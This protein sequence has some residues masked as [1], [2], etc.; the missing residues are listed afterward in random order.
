MPEAFTE[1]FQKHLRS[2]SETV[3]KM[4][5]SN[6]SKE[7]QKHFRSFS[8]EFNHILEALQ[9]QIRIVSEAFSPK[10]CRNFTGTLEINSNVLSEPLRNLSGIPRNLTGTSSEPSGT[11]RNLPEPSGTSRNLWNQFKCFVKAPGTSRNFRNFSLRNLRA[12]GTW[13]YIALEPL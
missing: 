3:Q 9:M 1:A 5:K 10:S 8:K 4:F 6:L 13:L 7:S 11:S 12:P 2:I